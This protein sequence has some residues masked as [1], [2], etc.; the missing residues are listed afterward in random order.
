M[1]LKFITHVQPAQ[2]EEELRNLYRQVDKLTAG[3]GTA[4]ILPDGGGD[5]DGGDPDDHGGQLGT[6]FHWHLRAEWHHDWDDMPADGTEYTFNLKI[7]AIKWPYTHL[8]LNATV[9]QAIGLD[10][11]MDWV[12]RGNTPY[13]LWDRA[14]PGGT[15][16]GGRW[17]LESPSAVHY[18][19]DGSYDFGY[20][21]I[22]FAMGQY[23]PVPYFDAS[24]PANGDLAFVPIYPV[25]LVNSSYEWEKLKAVATLRVGDG[26]A[27]GF[28]YKVWFVGRYVLRTDNEPQQHTCY[29]EL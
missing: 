15:G 2:L 17:A 22:P 20:N 7:P 21:R 8:E 18:R 13:Y 24:I 4:I 26:H 16:A 9:L 10:V 29:W 5:G 1:P 12:I 25:R 27:G 11:S 28:C 23:T 3:S 14:V 6:V 19:L